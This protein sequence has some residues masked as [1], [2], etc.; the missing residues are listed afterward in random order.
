MKLMRRKHKFVLPLALFLLISLYLIF[1]SSND[2]LTV[3]HSH[4]DI[5]ESY[6]N[7]DLSNDLI[8]FLHF[9]KTGG[10]DWDRHLVHNLMHYD[11]KTNDWQ[12]MCKLAPNKTKSNESL[13]KRKYK[14]KKYYC[15]R[16]SDK[17]FNRNDFVNNWYFSRQTFG[18][19]CGLHA[20]Y[21]TLKICLNEI[22][23]QNSFLGQV[24]F[25]TI[26]REPVRRYL[27]EWNHIKRGGHAW[28]RSKNICN[29]E[30]FVDRCLR[31]NQRIEEISLEQFISCRNNIANN[32]Q[33]RMLADYGETDACNLFEN[34]NKKDLVSNAKNVLRNLSFFALNEYQKESQ[35][36]FEKIFKNKFRFKFKRDQ[37]I[38]ET[39]LTLI[40]DLSRP[41]FEKIINLNELDIELYEFAKNLF[42][43]RLDFYR[44][45][46]L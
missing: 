37:S 18:W 23:R 40:N 1:A 11:D 32:R 15:P 3:T 27:S 21:A 39:A 2:D 19:F 42:F 9:Q 44:K 36:L 41:V 16:G 22:K 13:H 12:N 4:D 7:F 38:N 24:F 28:N 8:V 46:S 35:E 31:P 30:I 20:D 6:N 33:T 10:S 25:T 14:Y 5:K 29:Q 34:E 43:K 45:N 17:D 26:I